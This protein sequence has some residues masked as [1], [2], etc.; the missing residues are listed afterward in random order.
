MLFHVVL[1][2]AKSSEENKFL[3]GKLTEKWDDSASPTI[4][5]V[6][7]YYSREGA[8]NRKDIFSEIAK[9]IIN[10]R[11]KTNFFLMQG[12]RHNLSSLRPEKIFCETKN[13]YSY[14]GQA[15][16]RGKTC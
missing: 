8:N 13:Q 7:I 5:E 11:A 9:I 15:T 16:H 4:K 12:D 1:K 10:E 2:M 6:L 3:L 14:K